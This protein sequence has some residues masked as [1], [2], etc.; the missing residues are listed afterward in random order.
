MTLGTANE[1][2]HGTSSCA[3]SAAFPG[4][5]LMPT[6]TQRNR[7]ASCPVVGSNSEP[8][9]MPPP[10][11]PIYRYGWCVREG[12]L[13]LCRHVNSGAQ[14]PA[15]LSLGVMSVPQSSASTTTPHP[16]DSL[17]PG[18]AHGGLY[19]MVAS[20]NKRSC[21]TDAAGRVLALARAP[22]ALALHTKLEGAATTLAITHGSALLA[23]S[24]PQ[25]W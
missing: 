1:G 12:S 2:F 6:G 21:C 14:C 4:M 15:L 10:Q 20:R 22:V 3:G 19:P 11:Y 7:E 9:E 13:A 5:W 18:W 17:Y 25:K 23:Q 16:A 8:T 24:A